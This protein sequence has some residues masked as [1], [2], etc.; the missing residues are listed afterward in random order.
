MRDYAIF[1]FLAISFFLL[2]IILGPLT[3][4]IVAFLII[5]P[6]WGVFLV[7]NGIRFLK[8]GKWYLNPGTV[9]DYFFYKFFFESHKLMAWIYIIIGMSLLSIFIGVIVLAFLR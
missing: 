4:A 5:I 1:L 7:L 3:G 8:H 9:F 2:C 6:S